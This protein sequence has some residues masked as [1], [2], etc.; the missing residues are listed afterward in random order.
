[1]FRFIWLSF[2]GQPRK[3]LSVA[4]IFGIDLAQPRTLYFH[5][6]KGK[7]EQGGAEEEV[8]RGELDN[9]SSTLASTPAWSYQPRPA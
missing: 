6:L 7:G 9:P 5:I 4:L 8:V 3:H 2:L 1:M